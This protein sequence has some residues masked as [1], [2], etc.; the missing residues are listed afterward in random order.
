MRKPQTVIFLILTLLLILSFSSC[1]KND[2]S[3]QGNINNVETSK[4][5]DY[6]EQ[7]Y[8][9][10]LKDELG[11]N[12]VRIKNERAHVS[13][14]VPK[15]WKVTVKNARHIVMQAPEDD[16]VLP[17]ITLHCYN[18]YYT[19]STTLDIST[20]GSYDRYF[21][22][23]L[24]LSEFMF[25]GNNYA[26][27]DLTTPYT[28]NTD[29]RFTNGIDTVT[30][31]QYYDN[32]SFYKTTT[33]DSLGKETGLYAYYVNWQGTPT[34]FTAAFYRDYKEECLSLLNYMVSSMK[35]TEG[36][37]V[38]KT[39][40]FS[41]GD[42]TMN[43]LDIFEKTDAQNIL[44]VDSD[45]TSKYSGFKIGVFHIDEEDLST[46]DVMEKY[47]KSIIRHFTRGNIEEQFEILNSPG[48]SE[49]NVG[50]ATKTYCYTILNS[51][52]LKID[53]PY[54]AID[55]YLGDSTFYTTYYI[56]DT[57]DKGSNIICIFWPKNQVKEAAQIEEIIEKSIS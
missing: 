36:A 22:F 6:E 42:V 37:T 50:N 15:D 5:A 31:I 38:T 26:M 17:G 46:Y 8:F 41:A 2:D 28:V 1:S 14:D 44:A 16:E 19:D 29:T 21:Q 51:Y 20:V 13:F 30:S 9:T 23:D 32:V 49:E 43:V 27:Y 3:E 25:D 47:G 57:K 4:D 11:Y 12:Y 18:A 45:D 33:H 35:Y 10:Q 53:A 34:L 55:Y 48:T 52:G 24:P 40:E 39:K 54:N 7:N 56:L